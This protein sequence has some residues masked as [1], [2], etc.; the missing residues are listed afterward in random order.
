MFDTV[1]D[2]LQPSASLSLRLLATDL[3]LYLLLDITSSITYS[4]SASIT[5]NGFVDAYHDV[6]DL[7][8]VPLD[9]EPML[10]STRTIT[11]EVTF[12]TMDDGTNRA[13]FNGQTFNSP[14]VPTVMSAMSLGG[15][16]ATTA[17]AYGPYTFILD[18]LEVVDIVLQNGD[19]GKHP[20]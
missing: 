4:S 8:L 11:L 14:L 17:S 18:H 10:P 7:D 12:D 5:D 6:P 13:M 3:T 2:T 19:A 16:N 15:D 1:P 9:V 20:L